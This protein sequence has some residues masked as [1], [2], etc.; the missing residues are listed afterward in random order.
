MSLYALSLGATPLVVGTL[1]HPGAGFN[2]DPATLDAS[3]VTT[4]AAKAHDQ[5][6][7]GFLMNIIP[8]T[9]VGAFADGDILQVL[10]FSVLF[11]FGLSMLGA[12]GQPL[13]DVLDAQRAYN[14]TMST[15]YG[16]QADYR[17]ATSRLEAA[18][19]QEVKP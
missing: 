13:I 10:F 11:A 1:I 8:G 3:T 14:E 9:I 18:V 4:Y 7:T 2:I 6:V 19:G 16:A 17:R 12:R 15:Y 5:S